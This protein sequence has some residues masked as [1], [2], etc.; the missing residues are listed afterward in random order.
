MGYYIGLDVSQ[1]QTAICVLDDRG[2]VVAEGKAATQ[3]CAIH[4]WLVVKNI[5]LVS[6]V[7][8]GLEAGA[9][10][11]WL[12]AGLTEMGLP[13][14]CL[15]AFQ[16]HRFLKT[17]RNKTDRN[18]AR[19]LAQ[20]V[21]MGG[22]FIRPVAIRTQVSQEARM[23]LTLRQSLVNQKVSLENNITGSLKPFGLVVPR[24]SICAARFRE[25]VLAILDKAEALGL[26]LRES[27]MPSL[28]LYES[29]CQQLSLLNQQVEA[30]AKNHP[31]CRKLMTAPGVGPIIALSFVTA[32]DDPRRF[33][34]NG[35]I[36]AYFGLTPKQYQSGETDQQQ[37][38]SRLGNSMTRQHLVQAATVLLVSSKKWSTLKAWGMKIAKKRGFSKARIAVARKLAIILHRMWITNEDFRWATKAA[39]Q[40]IAGQAAG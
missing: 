21:R 39:E 16:A 37:G 12:S 33:S 19:G 5:S 8:V 1:R 15:E 29:L 11:F 30:V 10:S 14:V 25:R 27:V 17:C 6:V 26:K 2:H 36:G 22:A 3:P 7:K 23:L 20:L 18:D 28:D 9:M 32:V 35:D 13:M 40:G 38:I 31:I 24:G 4:G 34:K